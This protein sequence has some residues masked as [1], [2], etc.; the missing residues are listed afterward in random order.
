MISRFTMTRL[1]IARP[2]S[3]SSSSI[4]EA[5][6]TV[7]RIIDF[8][9]QDDASHSKKEP[10]PK[11]AS[12]ILQSS[13]SLTLPLPK[14][15]S[16][17]PNTIFNVCHQGSTKVVERLG[18]F[19]SVKNPGYFWAIPL[20][21]QIYLVDGRENSYTVDP[22]EGVTTSDNVSVTLSGKVYITFVNPHNA[23]YGARDP[24][25]NI[26]S[27]AK[28]AM[29]CAIGELAL[30]DIFHNRKKVNESILKTMQDAVAPWGAIITRY[31]ILEIIPDKEVSKSMDLQAVSERKRREV[32]KNAEGAKAE[33]ILVSEGKRIAEENNAIAVKIAAEAQAQANSFTIQRE[34]E[35]NAMRVKAEAEANAFKIQKE[36]EAKAQ[37]TV[38]AF[39]A[40]SRGLELL[41]NELQSTQDATK[42]MLASQY[43]EAFGKVAG[44][45]SSIIVPY[46]PNADFASFLSQTLAVAKK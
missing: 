5:A 20:I 4:V 46:G 37:A 1:P 30:D 19:H 43:I 35:A 26:L 39:E 41:A 3:S 10:L 15:V 31:E 17:S 12:R 2:F 38:A 42:T 33:M 25:D 14:P 18:K 24:L 9:G 45:N 7:N 32:V 23:V 36:A 8:V 16:R 40:Q 13:K 22:Q 29:R 11:P 21:D 27:H 28:S 44:T 34:A 6:K